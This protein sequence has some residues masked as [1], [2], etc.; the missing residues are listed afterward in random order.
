M[1]VF[2]FYLLNQKKE[3]NFYSKIVKEKKE[4]LIEATNQ[5]GKSTVLNLPDGTSVVLFPGSRLSYP[6]IFKNSRNV[7]LEG[8]AFFEVTKNP[9]K[10]FLVYANKLVSK[11]LG[12]SFTVKA[13]AADSVVNVTVKTGRV[14]VFTEED[15]NQK[16]LSNRPELAGLVLTPNQ[17][18]VYHLADNRLIRTLAAE[19]AIVN[20]KSIQQETFSFNKTPVQQ[21][22]K[23][24]QDTYG[25]S[26]IYNEDLLEGCELTG[27]LGDE[28]LLEKMNVICKAIDGSY[29]MMD[30]QII[31]T[32]K[33]CK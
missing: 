9:Q 8:E 29:E 5:T 13:Y 6:K 4:S 31:V 24:L 20:R 25:I 32:N 28:P 15:Q 2:V 12:T 10:P 14:S 16:K 11:V 1:S 18:V 33:G 21:V 22:F 27:E 26:I 7:Y 23:L 17:Q 30:A 19:P 3:N